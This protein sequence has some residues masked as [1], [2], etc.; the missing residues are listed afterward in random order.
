MWK[1]RLLTSTEL[2]TVNQRFCGQNL[3]QRACL[4]F[5]NHETICFTGDDFIQGK[6]NQHGLI[7]VSRLLD[8]AQH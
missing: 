6:N 5:I 4:F 2:R 8:E 3:V 7:S 1:Q